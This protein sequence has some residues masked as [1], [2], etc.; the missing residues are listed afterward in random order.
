MH[1][2]QSLAGAAS[3]PLAVY[4]GYNHALCGASLID[5]SLKFFH[6]KNKNLNE[7]IF[8]L[9]DLVPY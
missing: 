6:L 8:K 3:Y 9:Y 7:V 5:K 4:Y 2:E 1:S